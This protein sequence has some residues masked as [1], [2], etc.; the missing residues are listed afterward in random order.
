MAKWREDESEQ[1]AL[2]NS[3]KA[4]LTEV[5]DRHNEVPFLAV[6]RKQVSLFVSQ[7]VQAHAG[8]P[9]Q[10]RSEPTV[11]SN[12]GITHGRAV[13]D[14][15]PSVHMPD[16]G[17]EHRSLNQQARAFPVYRAAEHLIG[18]KALAHH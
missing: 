18:A 15:V 3:I 12:Q 11:Q 7:L 5:F 1:D 2:R 14:C 10:R 6:Y 8:H 4:F 9:T 17:G 16:W 13:A